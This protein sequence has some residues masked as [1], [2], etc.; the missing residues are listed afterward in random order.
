MVGVGGMVV[1]EG[2]VGL[3]LAAGAGA[4]GANICEG[5]KTC[6]DVPLPST[7]ES[8]FSSC[9]NSQVK[10]FDFSLS[11]CSKWGLGD[12]G[13]DGVWLLEGLWNT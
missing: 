10:L 6:P 4:P 1:K 2:S 7:M 9:D 8:K 13:R 11:S 3:G 5:P 12:S